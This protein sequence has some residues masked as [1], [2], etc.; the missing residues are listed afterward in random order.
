MRLSLLILTAVALPALGIL[1]ADV[2]ATQPKEVTPLAQWSGGMADESL[3]K[4]APVDGVIV[5]A[6]AFAKLCKAWNVAAKAP[7]DF[8]TQFVAVQT[9][10]GSIIHMSAQ[11]GGDGEMKVLGMAT[12]DLVPGFR[13][14]MLVLPRDGVKTVN[15]KKLGA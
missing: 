10:G 8:K 9:T 4:Q 6:A 11:L 15:G 2:P 3:Q 7:V 14:Q 12:M 13:Y 5:E 1:A